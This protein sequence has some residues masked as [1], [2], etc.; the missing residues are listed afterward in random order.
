MKSN[1]AAQN[2]HRAIA[3][4]CRRDGA[5]VVATVLEAEGSTPCPAG[6]KALIELSGAIHGTVGGGSAEAE[7]QRRA[8]QAIRSGRVE[9]FDVSLEGF[10]V[11]EGKPICGG[12]MRIL[13]DPTAPKH[14]AVYQAASNLIE[15]RERGVLLTT[16]RGLKE[17]Q[18]A[19]QLLDENSITP[20]VGFPGAER[21]R[22]ALQRQEALLSTSSP[23][24]G[25][26]EQ[27][28]VLV[29]PLIPK[30]LL[31]IFGGGH[32]GQAL[33]AQA[34]LVGFET[35][36]IDDRPEFARPELFPEGTAVCCGGISEAL[37]T[38]ALRADTY[39][40]SVTRGHEQ[41]AKVLAACIRQPLAYL[42]MIGSRRKVAMLRR[43]F[44]ESGRAT[45]E[46]FD[47]VAAPIGLD[48]GAVTVPEIAA[49]IVA[50][51]IAVRRKG[52][53]ASLSPQ[54]AP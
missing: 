1:S 21:I 38:F 33:A 27:L 47:R 46:E 14:G 32:I 52:R 22:S 7:T 31:L 51:L 23:G 43:E 16:L 34:S 25:D 26:P 39:V 9:V 36:V 45:A 42:G 20:E 12:R 8:V 24:Q 11:G 2:I 17:C 28:A 30:P 48:I 44:I 40:V 10:T 4:R 6:A 18:V 29:E 15:R 5:F 37:S 3:E 49:S 54:P 41:D 53:A 13:I 50:Q 35:A 19:V